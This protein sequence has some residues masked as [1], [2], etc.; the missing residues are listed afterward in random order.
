MIYMKRG[1]NK[2]T[3]DGDSN[4]DTVLFENKEK[5][6]LT[7][8]TYK[9]YRS[10]VNTLTVNVKYLSNKDYQT[11]KTMLTD[12]TTTDDFFIKTEDG[13]VFLMVFIGDKIGLTKQEDDN[14]NIYW[15]GTWNFTE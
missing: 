9:S 13:E 11:F 4:P 3:F 6:F 15:T 2:I 12:K 7:G 8:K 1:S 14:K 5:Q 10:L